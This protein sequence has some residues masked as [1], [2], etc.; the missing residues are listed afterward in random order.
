MIFTVRKRKAIALTLFSIISLQILLPEVALAL[1]SGPAQPE[2]QGFLPAGVSDMVDLSTG[3]FKYN[4]PL[5]DVDGYP[6][7]LNYQSGVGVEDEAGWVGL[8]WNLNVGSINR[9][10]RGVPDDMKGDEV[11][12]THYTKPHITIGGRLRAKAEIGGSEAFVKGEGTFTIGIFNDNYTGIGAEIGVNPGISLGKQMDGPLTASLGVGL[13]SSTTSG[14]DVSPYMNFNI[15]NKTDE[16]VTGVAGLSAALGYNTRSGMKSLTLGASYGYLARKDKENVKNNKNNTISDVLNVL[17]STISYNTEPIQPSIQV[18]YKTDYFAVSIDVGVAGGI[19]YGGVGGMGYRTISQVQSPAIK[20]PVYGF[21][22]AEAGKNQPNAMMDFIREKDVPVTPGLPKLAVPVALPDLFTYSS[23]TGSGQFRLFRG[24]TGIY[25][26]AKTEN[27][28]NADSYGFEAG[29]GAYF[30]GG[31]SKYE[32]DSRLTTQKWTRQNNYLP[33]GDFQDKSDANPSYQQVYFKEIGQKSAESSSLINPLKNNSPV[34]VRVNGTTASGAFTD[35]VP[36]TRIQKSE[37]EPQRTNISYLTNAECATSGLDKKIKYYDFLAAGSVPSKTEHVLDRTG[38]YRKGHHISEMTVTDAAGARMVYGIPVYNTRQ[39]EYTFAIGANA[40][41]AYSLVSGSQDQVSFAAGQT[42]SN[43]GKGKG[44][45]NYYHKSETAPYAASYLLSGILSPD[46]VDVSGNGISDDDQG[47][48]IRFNYSYIPKYCWRSPYKNAT[49]NKGLMADADD[50]KANIIYGE[51]ELYYVHSIESKTKIAYFITADRN[52][53]LG[54]N[55]FS[56]GVNSTVRQKMLKEIRLY[57]KGDMSRP[58]KV[59]KFEYDYSLCPGVPNNTAAAPNNGKLTLKKVYFEYRGTAKGQSFPYTFSYKTSFTKY[60]GAV[61]NNVGYSTMSSDRWGV[62]HPQQDNPF[63]TNLY[64]DHFPYSVQNL[65]GPTTGVVTSA[66]EAASVWHLSHINLP[67]GGGIDINYEADDYAYVQDKKAMVMTPVTTLIA[68][69]ASYSAVASSNL[70][71]AKGIQI[72]VPAG[73]PAM[74]DATEWFRRTFLNGSPYLYTKIFVTLATGLSNAK[75]R[76]DDYVACFAEIKK[77]NITSNGKA[78]II[79]KDRLEAGISQN[80]I[81]FAAWQKIKEEYPR[82]A[83]P[84]FD[85]RL[86]GDAA[87]QSGDGIIA[88][89]KTAISN[90]SELKQNFYQRA[91][92]KNY[93]STGTMSKSFVRI[94]KVDGHKLGGGVRVKKISISDGWTEGRTYGQAYD[95]S[96]TEDGI[97]ISSGVASYEPAI[98]NDENP[99]HQPLFY[100]QRNK[101]AL[102]NLLDLEEPFG[103]SYFPAPSV[104]YSKVT[105]SDL[106]AQQ[107]PYPNGPTGYTVNEFYTAR[108]FPVQIRSTELQSIIN[109]P[110][111]SYGI[112]YTSSIQQTTL[113]QGYSIELNDMHGKPK[114][115]TIFNQAGAEV[116]STKTYYN[117]AP[118]NGT[119][120]RLRNQV[121]VVN[122][123][124]TVEQNRVIGRDVDFFTDFREQES[125]NDGQSLNLGI[126]IVPA[127]GFPIPIPHWPTGDNSE[128]KLFRS[129]C[130]VKVS[131]YYGVVDSIVVKTN[132]SSIRTSNIAYDAITGMPLITSTQ[133]EF[134]SEIYSVKIPAYWGYPG[135]GPGSKRNGMELANV[136]SSSAAMLD[137]NSGNYLAYGDEFIDLATGLRYWIVPRHV[138][139]D[140]ANIDIKTVVDRYGNPVSKTFARVKVVRSSRNQLDATMNELVML[141][142]PIVPNS[143][144][145]GYRIAL[146]ESDLTGLHV[147]NASA[148]TYDENW[149]SEPPEIQPG[150]SDDPYNF[151]IYNGYGRPEAP[152]HPVFLP[153]IG[154]VTDARKNYWLSR[155]QNALIGD[156]RSTVNGLYSS[157]TN[158]KMVIYTSFYVPRSGVYYFGYNSHANLSFAFSNICS[159]NFNV[160]NYYKSERGWRVEQIDLTKGWT[161]LVIEISVGPNPIYNGI[162]IEVYD[163]AQQELNA[164]GTAGNTADPTLLFSTS[165]LKFSSANVQTVQNGTTYY[166]YRYSDLNRTGYSPCILPPVGINPYVY[167]F[168]GN[169]RPYQAEVFQQNRVYANAV[170]FSGKVMNVK[171]AGYLANFYNYWKMPL[172]GS[173]WSMN[174][175]NLENWVTTNTVTLYDKF[176]QELQNRDA[177]GR[178]SAAK[179][180]FNGELPAAVASNAG[181]RE[182]YANSFED[183]RFSPGKPVYIIDPARSEFKYSKTGGYIQDGATSAWSHTGNSSVALTADSLVLNTLVHMVEEKRT[184][185]LDLNINN[186]FIKDS[187]KGAYTNGFQPLPGQNYIADVWVKDDAPFVT[188]PKLKM[189]INGQERPLTCKAVVEGWKLLEGTFSTPANLGGALQVVFYPAISTTIYLDDLRIHPVAAMMKTYSYDAASM[190]LMAELDENCLATLYE[191]DSQGTLIRVKKETE[192]GVMTI[193]E[194][195]SS[196]KKTL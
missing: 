63:F 58:I 85:R 180:D 42:E 11:E 67:T 149:N 83:Y 23:Q 190:R 162:G 34:A 2:M 168:K 10:L 52:D 5:L 164:F 106:D 25:F 109:A 35:D 193:K 157:G 100:I 78:N 192:R 99:L 187:S 123:D 140:I 68:D 56:G 110:K 6:V 28:T 158:K 40:D 81:I 163:C 128:Y 8:G 186:Q 131:Q 77:V 143:S 169:W 91:N 181:Y 117:T 173:V 62:Y 152:S 82:Y 111:N 21:L 144:G 101:G 36:L 172:S 177:L 195:R 160:S 129:A 65:N 151:T 43:L 19:V 46:Y 76:T 115:T 90:L 108:D 133:N 95:Y 174:T 7:N 165:N 15:K 27:T 154:E 135:M 119:S 22:Y 13:M 184:S 105:V 185:Y 112:V 150:L 120:M 73:T 113:S 66:G 70:K 64:N 18:P 136:T 93:A 191:Y 134:N 127:F 61:V 139:S 29:F 20:N 138:S 189:F 148:K 161:P 3:D 137:N 179:F 49:L 96:T 97:S 59:V 171:D 194:T 145:N 196:Q 48:A 116:S 183:A 24:G 26:D 50:D 44:I 79:F 38:G 17:N 14:V 125:I 75:G 12:T 147:I 54:V 39:A 72:N 87:S 103:E 16:A 156:N 71:A 69:N 31:A 104:V 167:G 86:G 166:Q 41:G 176:G 51:K 32:Q 57:S 84:G 89:I 178:N 55:D 33:V 132:G 124:G 9:Q 92:S 142:N 88:A 47:T 159:N 130:A 126:D 1:T 102:T 60:T 155:E 37:R 188:T 30:H 122:P 114:A 4:I 182:I 175:G 121:S 94:A 107:N 74:S 80:P 45:D 170:S 98:G 141:T 153:G 146:N 53:A 118:L